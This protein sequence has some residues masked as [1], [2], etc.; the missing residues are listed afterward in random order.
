MNHSFL[1]ITEVLSQY[2]LFSKEIFF[3][4]DIFSFY[5]YDYKPFE[6]KEQI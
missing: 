5:N 6:G 2:H 4:S 3:I 1:R